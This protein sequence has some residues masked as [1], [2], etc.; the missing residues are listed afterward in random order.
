MIFTATY[1][2]SD[3]FATNLSTTYAE[4]YSIEV[5]DCS[6]ATAI[7]LTAPTTWITDFGSA[8]L[9]STIFLE[10]AINPSF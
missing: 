5:L 6:S 4:N 3:D 1:T 10:T 2:I 7:N 9:S 8:E